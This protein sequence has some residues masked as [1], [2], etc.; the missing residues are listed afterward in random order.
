MQWWFDQ[1]LSPITVG[2]S[3]LGGLQAR[4]R[5]YLDGGSRQAHNGGFDRGDPV[6]NRLGGADV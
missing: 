6:Q 5:G 2:T 4:W 1:W 3:V